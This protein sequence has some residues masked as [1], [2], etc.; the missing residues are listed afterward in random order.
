M[1]RDV[2]DTSG[3]DFEPDRSWA[4]GFLNILKYVEESPVYKWSDI[5]WCIHYALL[6]EERLHVC[7]MTY[8]EDV[9]RAAKLR[10]IIYRKSQFA[11]TFSY[12][13]HRKVPPLHDFVDFAVWVSHVGYFRLKAPTMT[14]AELKHAAEWRNLDKNVDNNSEHGL[15]RRVQENAKKTLL[16][17]RHDLLVSWAI[18][19]ADST[20]RAPGIE[21]PLDKVELEHALDSA[22]KGKK[23]KEVETET[24]KEKGKG[25]GKGRPTS[26]WRRA[27]NRVFS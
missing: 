11:K 1:W 25:K 17:D 10:C 2:L 7:P 19:H 8:L 9:H 13:G 24:G 20:Q 16:I 12:E 6:V 22:L 27:K 23:E 15:G 18:D 5:L 21:F 4:H 3:H 14:R 26:I